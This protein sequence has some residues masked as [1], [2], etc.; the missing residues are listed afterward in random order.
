MENAGATLSWCDLGE[1]LAVTVSEGRGIEEQCFI[2][3]PKIAWFDYVAHEIERH[4]LLSWALHALGRWANSLGMGHQCVIA[5]F[6]IS[7][8]IWTPEQLKRIPELC[9][10]VIKAQPH[11]FIFVRNVQVQHHA[12]LLKQL[13]GFGFYAL[14]A[15]VVYEFDLRQGANKKSSQLMRDMK[16][17]EK[18]DLQC[19][20][21]SKLTSEESQHLQMLY[22]RIY[23]L[24]HGPFNAKYTPCFFA[25]MVNEARMTCLVMKNAQGRIQA[26][27]L[28]HQVGDTLTVPALGY[29][30]GPGDLGLYRALCVEIFRLTLRRG[31]LL[32]YSSGAGEFKRKRGGQPHLEYTLVKP[33]QSYF[34]WKARLLGCLELWGSRL[35]HLDLI[36]W[37]A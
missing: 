35:S 4:R 23:I 19:E 17:R 24:K 3:S 21:L 6:P 33:P 30:L 37:G 20:I 10:R 12:D 7:T 14:P 31:L 9:A 36:A 32:N 11:R 16:G 27:A 34:P 1:P 28:L 25:D 13:K 15:R 22:E 18:L 29:D 8:N 26:F 5:N 2:T